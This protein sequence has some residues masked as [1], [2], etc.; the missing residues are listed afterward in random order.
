MGVA[1][2]VAV[3]AIGDGVEEFARSE[4]ERTTDLQTITA[5]PVT[6][7]LI[8]DV[9]VPRS[10][11][12]VFSI[13]DADSLGALLAGRATVSVVASG[14]GLMTRTPSS[15]PR[16]ASV[17]ATTPAAAERLR[18]TFAAG[19]FMTDAELRAGSRVVVQ[20]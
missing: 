9:R 13:S 3:L 7:E 16:A 11:Y 8:D 14:H 20:W 1:S 19:R 15:Q 17:T 5:S 2:L 10:G 4:L 18:L 6:Y 12:P